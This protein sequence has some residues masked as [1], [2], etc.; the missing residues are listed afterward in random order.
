MR[1]AG[2]SDYGGKSLNLSNEK[3]FIQV[4]PEDESRYHELKK[5]YAQ[6]KSGGHL[7]IE[8]LTNVG[9]SALDINSLPSV[10]IGQMKKIL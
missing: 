5:W 4:E 10:T 1:G 9:D 3:S 6:T 8:K 7:K 2:I